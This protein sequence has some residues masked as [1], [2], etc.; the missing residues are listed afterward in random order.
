MSAIKSKL[1][2][3]GIAIIDF[4]NRKSPWH[5]WL[6]PLMGIAPHIHDR[7]YMINEAADLFEKA[8]FTIEHTVCFLFTSRRLP[9]PLL[10]VFIIADFVLE[11]LPLINRFAGIIMIKG[12]KK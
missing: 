11:R 6:K 2:P 5:S 4:P 7:L 12:V 8:G 10:P 1:R 9:S 3:G